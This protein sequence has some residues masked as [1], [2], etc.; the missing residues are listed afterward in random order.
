[1]V[2][3]FS[4]VTAFTPVNGV[5]ITCAGVIRRFFTADPHNSGAA[6]I[7]RYFNWFS[8]F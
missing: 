8:Q 5:A 2:N 6:G 7:Y 1:V 4:P 3:V